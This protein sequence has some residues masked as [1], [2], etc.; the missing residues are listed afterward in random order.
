MLGKRFKSVLLLCCQIVSIYIA[1][2]FDKKCHSLAKS[3][4]CAAHRRGHFYT[5]IS[6]VLPSVVS[7]QMIFSDQCEGNVPSFNVAKIFKGRRLEEY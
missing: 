3:A 4:S 2:T 7:Q 5:E 1:A 6:G